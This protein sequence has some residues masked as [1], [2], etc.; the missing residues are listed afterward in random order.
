MFYRYDSIPFSICNDTANEA[1]L[2]EEL[3]D[4]R[5]LPPVAFGR[6]GNGAETGWLLLDGVSLKLFGHTTFAATL[7]SRLA[8]LG[9]LVLIGVIAHKLRDVLDP[10]ICLLIGASMLWMLHYG[11]TGFRATGAMFLFTIALDGLIDLLCDPRRIW[12][13]VRIGVALAFGIWTYTTIRCAIL[14]L[15]VI[16]IIQIIASNRRKDGFTRTWIKRFALIGLIGIVI[17]SPH[18][19]MAIS[20]PSTYFGRGRYAVRGDFSDWIRHVGASFLLPIYTPMEY[21]SEVGPAHIFDAVA[22]ALT[23]VKLS[24]ISLPTGAAALFWMARTVLRPCLQGVDRISNA[25]TEYRPC[26]PEMMFVLYLVLTVIITNVLIGFAGPSQTRLLMLAPAYALLAGL[27]LTWISKQLGHLKWVIPIGLVFLLALDWSRYFSRMTSEKANFRFGLDAREMAKAAS[28]L[29][30]EGRSSL[31]LLRLDPDVVEFYAHD[32]LSEIVVE[33][34]L[35]G[36]FESIPPDRFHAA[37]F[38]IV[39]MIEPD[40]PLLDNLRSQREQLPKI[41]DRWIAFGPAR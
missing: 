36:S 21:R 12:P 24:P 34:R 6:L 33:D 30:R 31:V 18:I 11:R 41:S 38:V 13:A 8:A 7:P 1:L 2:G 32:Q 16:G 20:D 29:A 40:L 26:H 9:T 3:L 19:W 23:T 14:A 27:A 15:I 22:S 5:R 39:S 25:R 37:D 10:V 35:G 17:C 4:A 28:S